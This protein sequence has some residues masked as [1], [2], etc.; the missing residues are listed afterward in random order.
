MFASNGGRGQSINNYEDT[1]SGLGEHHGRESS[2][3]H[4]KHLY[5]ID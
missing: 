5:E 4:D 2:I 1:G 3:N